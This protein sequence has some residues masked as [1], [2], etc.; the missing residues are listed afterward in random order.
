MVF[1]A[2]T[3]FTQSLPLGNGRLGAMM[4][5]GVDE[6]RI[7]LNE[8]SVWRMVQQALAPALTTGIRYDG[9]GGV[10]PNLF[11]TSPP[12]QIDGNFG[13]TAAIAEMLVQSKDGH[14]RL[15]PALPNTWKDGFVTGLCARGGFE[16]S[17]AWKNGR[18]V[19]AKIL[20][21]CAGQARV[22]YANNENV[23]KMEAGTAIQLNEHLHVTKMSRDR[24]AA[25]HCPTSRK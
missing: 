19:T 16:V 18:L 3:N 24:V 2:G 13:T 21:H 25:G 17:L 4:F 6:E 10:Y 9:G 8:S 23:F 22:G 20:S 15:L 5:G 7:V 1:C 14:I 11:D 12:F